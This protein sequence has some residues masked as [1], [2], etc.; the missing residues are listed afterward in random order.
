MARTRTVDLLPR[1]LAGVAV[2]DGFV[3]AGY[4]TGLG[5]VG[6]DLPRGEV[7]FKEGL[8]GEMMFAGLRGLC[9]D[10]LPAFAISQLFAAEFERFE[11]L[12]EVLGR[13]VRQV[14]VSD[15]GIAGAAA[16]GNGRTGWVRRAGRPVGA[17][18]DGD[19]GAGLRFLDAFA[20][21][22]R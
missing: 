8:G 19:C 17:F 14:A 9:A 6:A 18:D 3:I 16:R 4:G 12:G 2:E 11:A 10:V 7:F 20:R 22:G 1:R 5:T 21:T 15:G 13:P